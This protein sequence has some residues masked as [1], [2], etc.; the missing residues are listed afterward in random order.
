VE[1]QV[2]EDEAGIRA[3]IES[4]LVAGSDTS[5]AATQVARALEGRRR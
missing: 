3:A 4:L 2:S 5:Q 1:E